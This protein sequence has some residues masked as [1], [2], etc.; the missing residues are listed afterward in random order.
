MEIQKKKN[1]SQQKTTMMTKDYEN[2][3]E[4]ILTQPK[5]EDSSDNQQEENW[6]V[7]LQEEE[8][9]TM[10]VTH[11]LWKL[12]VDRSLRQTRID[13]KTWKLSIISRSEERDVRKHKQKNE[14]SRKKSVKES[15]RKRKRVLQ[16]YQV[17]ASRTLETYF[18]GVPAKACKKPSKEKQD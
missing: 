2:I 9:Q 16:E 7:S 1:H 3:F 12:G 10:T 11:Q 4:G 18:E 17:H 5:M 14:E 6:E 8:V 15:G 13:G